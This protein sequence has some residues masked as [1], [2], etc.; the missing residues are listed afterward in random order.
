METPNAEVRNFAFIPPTLESS[1]ASIRA[2][3]ERFSGILVVADPDLKARTN[4]LYTVF[5]IPVLSFDV[6]RGTTAHLEGRRINNEDGDHY[7]CCVNTRQN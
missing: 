5:G 1:D 4:E 3:G 2:A 6:V 7:P